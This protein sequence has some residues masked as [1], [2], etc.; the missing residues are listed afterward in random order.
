MS[1]GTDFEVVDRESGRGK[2]WE[3][4]KPLQKLAKKH[5]RGPP[6]L[7]KRNGEEVTPLWH[8]LLRDA[9]F[10]LGLLEAGREIASEARGKGCPACGG[11]LHAA[12][13]W[14]KPRSGM[15]LPAEYDN[16]VQFLLRR[17]GVSQ[18]GDAGRR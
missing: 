3:K 12:G 4:E 5:R 18:T 10:H 14:R 2:S 15:V 1:T 7:W 13:F 8:K 11:R 9:R 17:R 16:P 6:S